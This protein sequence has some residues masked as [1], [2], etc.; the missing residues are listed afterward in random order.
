ML[1]LCITG[2]DVDEAPITPKPRNIIAQVAD[3]GTN[4][5]AR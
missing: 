1:A 2:F 4:G 5:A 3:S